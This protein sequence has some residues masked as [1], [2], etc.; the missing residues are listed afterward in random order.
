ME[1]LK[2]LESRLSPQEFDKLSALKNEK[3]LNFITKYVKLC[4]PKSVF[5]RTD[6][7]HDIQ[8]IREKAIQLKE[9]IS[10]KIKGHTV[11]FDGIYDQARDKKNTKF[12]VEKDKFLKGL[13][14]IE[15]EKGLKEIY[16]LLKN[17]M[18]DKEMFVLF[19]CLGPVNSEFSIYAVQITDSSY[20]A[21]SE[22]ILY[23]PAYEIFRRNPEIDFFKYVHSQG[24]LDEFN[25]SK[26][27]DNISD[28]QHD[29]FVFAP[30]VFS[31]KYPVWMGTYQ[32]QMTENLAKTVF[33]LTF[34]PKLRILVP[35]AAGMARVKVHRFL[36]L[37]SISMALFISVFY[38]MGIFFFDGI[39]RLM[40]RLGDINQGL[41][42]AFLLFAAIAI[43]LL[44]GRY[45]SRK[46]K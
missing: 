13:N 45:I 17:I 41:L 43:S 46:A 18:Q 37:Q 6:D 28:N 19:L 16:T 2:F 34:V 5:I 12:L 20:V 38:P 24:E 22:D 27:I 11:H 31:E 36:L 9:E 39:K 7:P 3:V 8:Y 29:G 42:A 25:N 30:F 14:C 35:L 21:H 40:S 44:V 4:N 33:I 1:A 23:R 26:N 15:R 10:L 32:R